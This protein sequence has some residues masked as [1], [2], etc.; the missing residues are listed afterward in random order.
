[1]NGKN[2]NNRG[3]VQKKKNQGGIMVKSTGNPQGDQPYRGGEGWRVQFLQIVAILRFMVIFS[4]KP[5]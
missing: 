5:A 2:V 1:M 3:S 4:L